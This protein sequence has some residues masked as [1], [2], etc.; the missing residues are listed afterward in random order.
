MSDLSDLVQLAKE[1][2]ALT[3]QVKTL[4]QR[5]T[6]LE[7]RPASA[8]MALTLPA[9]ITALIKSQSRGDPALYRHLH[10]LATE[11]LA[12]DVS[13]TRVMEMVKQ[14]TPSRLSA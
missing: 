2:G 7:A 6:E 12:L 9:A 5:V 13:E 4:T 1:M 3:E 8:G 11:Q 14:G 10:D